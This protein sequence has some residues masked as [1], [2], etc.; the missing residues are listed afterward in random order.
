[1]AEIDELLAAENRASEWRMPRGPAD[2]WESLA[3]PLVGEC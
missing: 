2:R 1:M 3:D